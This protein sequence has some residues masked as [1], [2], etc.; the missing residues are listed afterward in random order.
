MVEDEKLAI[1]ESQRVARHEAIKDGVRSEVGSEI[2]RHAENL[3]EGEQAKVAA[4]GEEFKRK[5]LNEVVETEGEIERA[6]G[7]ARVSQIIDYCFYLVYGII[8]LEIILELFG[9]RDGNA[10]RQLVATLSSPLLRPFR[11]LFFDP[12]AGIFHLRLSYIVALVVYLLIHLSINGL[13]RMLAQR[14]TVI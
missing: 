2:K 6:R 13:L 5:A 7:I 8:G 4:V 9:A 1:D 14:K 12:S 3:N 11:G 10:F